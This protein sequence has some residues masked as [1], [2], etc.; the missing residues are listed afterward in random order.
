[1]A[2]LEKTS[3]GYYQLV[4]SYRDKEGKPRKKTLRYFGKNKPSEL[5]LSSIK[6]QPPKLPD[7]KFDIILVDPPWHYSLRK[8]DKTHRN[9]VKYS[10]MTINQLKR[11]KVGSIAHDNCYLFMW[12][13]KDYLK[14]GIE[15]LEH[16][17]FIY[18]NILTWVKVSKEGKIRMM[19]GH[20]GRNCS[21]F[22]LVGIKGKTASFTSLGISNIPTVFLA[23]VDNK[24]SK[25]PDIPLLDALCDKIPHAEKIDLFSRENKSNWFCWGDDSS[26][27]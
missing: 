23:E 17:G 10:T 12:V 15:L 24:H 6:N 1:M 3:K 21:E 27:H 5:E 19:T 16:W 26:L 8:D 14:E 18:K 20:W 11:L 9:R 22:I 2:R 4:E 25:K 7:K 13:T